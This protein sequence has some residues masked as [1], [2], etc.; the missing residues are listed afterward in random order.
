[1]NVAS[2]KDEQR[3]PDA[4]PN[5]EDEAQP[6]LQIGDLGTVPDR[7]PPTLPQPEPEPGQAEVQNDT[8][9]L[10]E[11]GVSREADPVDKDATFTPRAKPERAGDGSV[12]V[13]GGLPGPVESASTSYPPVAPP[14][15]GKTWRS[16]SPARGPVGAPALPGMPVGYSPAAGPVGMPQLGPPASPRAAMPGSFAHLPPP[17]QF[18]HGPPRGMGVPEAMPPTPRPEAFRGPT[19]PPAQAPGPPHAPAAG[20]AF[21]VPEQVATPEPEPKRS[22]PEQTR[23]RT[24]GG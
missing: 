23:P 10:A 22:P 16:G 21:Q 8:R 4:L 18:P 1:V 17:P 19:P 20:P 13:P 9:E 14:D 11:D 12:V 2:K 6:E 15:L 7:P 3:P 5:A 24:H